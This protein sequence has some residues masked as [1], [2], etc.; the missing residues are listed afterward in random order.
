[1]DAAIKTI[2]ISKIPV[3]GTYLTTLISNLALKR[4]LE[5]T[6]ELFTLMRQRIERVDEDKVDK[7][8]FKSEE[9]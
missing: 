5:R 2:I 6:A 4:S 3:L 9:F 8:F 1:M 7:A